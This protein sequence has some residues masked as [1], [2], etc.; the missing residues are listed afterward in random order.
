MQRAI[1]P[2]EGHAEAHPAP[3][4]RDPD[5]PSVSDATLMLFAGGALLLTLAALVVVAR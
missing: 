1:H 5:L 3:V 4:P 2:A